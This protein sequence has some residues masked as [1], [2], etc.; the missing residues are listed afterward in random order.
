M[1]QKTAKRL[2]KYAKI[3]TDSPIE[4][5]RYYRSIKARFTGLNIFIKTTVNKGI[6]MELEQSAAA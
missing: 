1:N 4:E 2:R 3:K 6:K 5:K